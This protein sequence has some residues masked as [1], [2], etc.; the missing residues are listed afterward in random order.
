[1]NKKELIYQFKSCGIKKGDILAVHSSLS[2]FGH[3][4]GGAFTIIESLQEIIT[5][6]GLLL[7]PT[8]TGNLSCFKQ[9]GF[10]PKKTECKSA[11]GLIPDTFWRMDNVKRSLHPTHS[12]AAWGEKADWLLEHHSPFTYA[13]EENTPFHK[14][15]LLGGKILLL[16]VK[17]TRNSS[18]H[19][20][21]YL[22]K[23]PYLEVSYSLPE[24]TT[25]LVE[26]DDGS[27][28]KVPLMPYTPGCSKKF[29][30][31]DSILFD[32]NVMNEYKVG[33]ATVYIVDSA[34]MMYILDPY[35]HTNPGMSLC[36][37][38]SCCENRKVFLEKKGLLTL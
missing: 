18:I 20:A 37:N 19:V 16:G 25:Y 21:E 11:V 6:Q 9:T 33:N 14:I 4:E 35:F 7:M 23:A 22:S 36:H 26:K 24:D 32:N 8:H 31:F 17:N 29:D 30:I 13:F 1:M 38:C 10:N 28:I 3:V 12:A 2:A 34:K 5:D 27:T 15:S